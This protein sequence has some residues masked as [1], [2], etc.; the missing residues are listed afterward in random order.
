MKQVAW[1]PTG[2]EVLGVIQLP[3]KQALNSQSYL[4]LLSLR[5]DNLAQD[6]DPTDLNQI[7]DLLMEAGLLYSPLNPMESMG[8]QIL[9]DNEEMLMRLRSLGIPGE[10][11]LRVV[12]NNPAA[13]TALSQTNLLGWTLETVSGLIHRE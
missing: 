2:Q 10:L 5:L 7:S 6:V 12:I 8:R 1:A 9:L 3:V 11:P 4:S 13:Q